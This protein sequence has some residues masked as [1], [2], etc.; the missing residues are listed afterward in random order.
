[1]RVAPTVGLNRDQKALLEQQSRGRSLPARIVERSR[2]ILLA[3]GG[4]QDKE[5]AAEL[6]VSVQKVARW[7]ARFLELGT[8]GLEKDAPR[9]GRTPSIAAAMVKRVIGLTTKEKPPNGT[10]WSTRT[11]AEA[12]GISEASV[13]RIWHK[14]GLKPHLV[15]TYKV[16][17][18]PEFAEKLNTIVGLY[19]NPPEHAIVLCCD[20]KSQIQALDRTQPGLPLK[21]GRAGTMTHDYKRNGTATLFAA[22]NTF[23]G[24]VI[25]MLAPR[26]RH[27]EW[28]DFL[29]I[30]DNNTPADKPLHLIADNYATHKH[31]K[32]QRWLKRHPRFHVHFTPTSA[33]WLNMVERFFRDL[34]VNRLRRGVF[35]DVIELVEAIDLYIDNHNNK[36]K[37]FIWTTSANDILEKVK[38]ARKALNNVQSV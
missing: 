34:T 15:E 30:V 19:L 7:R 18:D 1:M 38:R 31:A 22:L 23:D 35:R 12:V 26:H 13:R 8:V 32:V 27:Q 4:K 28:L 37:P 33:S 9:P 6:G 21:P 2:I 17:N 5:I 36:P 11:M 25:S 14:N 24:K 3:A 16:S 10:H 20:E 29:K